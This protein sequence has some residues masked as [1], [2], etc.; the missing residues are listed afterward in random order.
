MKYK[1][2]LLMTLLIGI[3]L[4]SFSAGNEKETIKDEVCKKI[5]PVEEN[6]FLLFTPANNLL[7]LL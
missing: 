1:S 2:F 6:D 5:K 7:F 3:S 4:I